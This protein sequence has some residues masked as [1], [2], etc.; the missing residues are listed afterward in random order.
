[1][2]KTLSIIAA[3]LVSGAAY[4][5]QG[6]FVG[7]GMEPSNRL[8]AEEQARIQHEQ[9]EEIQAQQRQIRYELEQREL[10]RANRIQEEQRYLRLYFEDC[11]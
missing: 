11:E 4:G 8:W 6:P 2:N 3:A 9:L 5:Q 1:M 10:F 7:P